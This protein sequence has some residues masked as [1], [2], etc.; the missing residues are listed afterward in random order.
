L[1]VLVVTSSADVAIDRQTTLCAK[2]RKHD[3]ELSF[4][5]TPSA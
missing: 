4:I 5:P 1:P 3:P 2:S